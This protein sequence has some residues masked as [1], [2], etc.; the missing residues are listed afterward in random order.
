MRI[1]N[2]ILKCGA[3]C[4]AFLFPAANGFGEVAVS[5]EVSPRFDWN[6]PEG[7]TLENDILSISLNEKNTAMAYSDYDLSQFAGKKVKVSILSRGKGVKRS[8]VSY[9]GFKVML[10]F[11]DEKSNQTQY[12]T[13][14]QREGDW[15]WCTIE[16]TFDLREMK[17]TDGKIYLGLQE[18][19]GAVDFNLASLRV[20][21]AQPLFPVDRSTTKCRYSKRVLDR[22]IQRGVMLPS[23]NCTEDDFKTLHEWGVTLARYQMVRGWG[24]PEANRDVD[25]YRRWIDS[26]IDHLVKDV[27]PWA[28]RYGIDI[29]VDVHVPPGGSRIDREKAMFHDPKLAEVFIDIWRTIAK[30]CNGHPRIWGYDLFN[31]PTQEKEGAEGCDYWTLQERAARAIRAIDPVTPIIFESL[32][33]DGPEAY[34]WMKVLNLPDIIYQVH[35]YYPH[36]YTHQGVGQKDPDKFKTLA[37]PNVGR[38]WNKEYLKE[39]LAPV[40]DFQKRHGAIIYVGEFSAIAWAPNAEQYLADCISIFEEY[41]WSWTYHAFR[42]WHGWDVEREADGPLETKPSPNNARKK[43]LLQGIRG[44]MVQNP[45]D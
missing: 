4:A 45:R 2:L 23:G 14:P 33:S 30:K 44:E 42:E 6:I 43:V 22:P 3:L 28:E 41:G 36:A 35:M 26:K 39:K 15:Q 18:T 40:L 11:V 17:P 34:E 9:F 31:E 5:G 10:M 8:H 16:A 27:L 29:V 38:G 37:Y 19:I 24:N 20:E 25:D 12:L 21:E 1:C 32:C 7:A 13:G